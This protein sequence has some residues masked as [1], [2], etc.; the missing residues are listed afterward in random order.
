MPGN[1]YVQC[2]STI[3]ATNKHGMNKHGQS[4]DTEDDAE[5]RRARTYVTTA[6]ATEQPAVYERRSVCYMLSHTH[7][8]LGR[9]SKLDC[10]K[11]NVVPVP[12]DTYY[13]FGKL[14]AR[15]FQRRPF[16]T[17]TLFQLHCGGIEQ[18]GP[19]PPRGRG[20]THRAVYGS[21]LVTNRRPIGQLT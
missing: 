13:V 19:S 15:S 12:S 3:R 20:G 2:C 7:T 4:A 1:I 21:Q 14:S 9:F 17:E 8:P 18:H 16:G 11:N 5:L 6:T 10:S